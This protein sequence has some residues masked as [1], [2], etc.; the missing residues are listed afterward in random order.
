MAR[1][2]FASKR[3]RLALFL[4]L[5]ISWTWVV[6]AQPAGEAGS[7]GN[8]DTS[9]AAAPSPDVG[10]PAV[11]AQ[12]S[13]PGDT[14]G[15]DVEGE[16]SAED[17]PA[18]GPKV[19]YG[20]IDDEIN[21]STS[22]FIK[23]LIDDAKE[24]D[25]EILLIDLNTFGG[26]IDAAVAIRDALLDAPMR[27]AVFI[28]KRAISAGALMSYA[29]DTIAISPGGTIGA[30][31]P[32]TGDGGEIPESVQEKY[33][34]YFR[35]EMRATA[36]TKGR[37][38]DIAEAMVDA[39]KVVE[40]VSAEG[41]LLT[42][43]TKDAVRLGVADFEAENLDAVLAEL[44]TTSAQLARVE[45]SWSEELAAFFTSQAISSML[46]LGMMLFGYLELQTPGFGFF[47]SAA[48]F[49]FLLLY[50]SHYLS[51]LAG[52][53][54]LLLFALGLILFGIELLVLPGIGVLAVAGTIAILTSVVMVLSAG[55]WTD[56]SF[57]NPFT[58]DAMQQVAI[59]IVL[60]FIALLLL[61]RTIAPATS[62]GTQGGLLLN[63]TLSAEAG[64][65]SHEEAPELEVELGARGAALSQLRPSGRVRFGERRVQVETEGDWIDK[66]EEVELVRRSEGRLIVRR[67]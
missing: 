59:V 10:A 31:M 25:A 54:E 34:S 1:R 33:L 14:D 36:E 53:E 2:P 3:F 63:E 50:F 26:R 43:G 7:G 18:T 30:A 35:E 39:E 9:P 6:I 58:V 66:G 28:N 45:R 16:A 12:D 64:Y 40:D 48:A 8:T 49:C 11:T 15:S 65:R 13:E 20:R 52:H 55:D 4:S 24:V 27:T 46:L 61:M 19:L 60:S 41:K 21:L 42:L 56:V 47:G 38:P 57:S 51:N 44:G 37:D 67:V 22:A 29:C 5:L 62:A 32:V 17:S 23:R